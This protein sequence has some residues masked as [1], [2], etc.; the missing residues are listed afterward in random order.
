MRKFIKHIGIFI[1]IFTL[2]G[3]TLWGAWQLWFNPYRN[4]VSNF[5]LSEELDTVLTSRQAVEDLDYIV[6]RVSERHPACIKALPDNLQL[7]Y[8]R[9]RE[10]IF[11]CRSV[12][13]VALA[14]ARILAV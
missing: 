5:R 11:R 9:E 8:E 6:R 14:A 4:T 2:C 3:T 12:G 1:C 13:F 10:A 7:E